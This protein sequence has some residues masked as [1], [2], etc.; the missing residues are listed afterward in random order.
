M[1]GYNKHM[2]TGQQPS[3]SRIKTTRPP[4]KATK[5]SQSNSAKPNMKTGPNYGGPHEKEM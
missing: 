2:K 3:G 5:G 4:G 1:K